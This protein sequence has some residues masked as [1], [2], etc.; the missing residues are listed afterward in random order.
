[1]HGQTNRAWPQR[2]VRVL[3]ITAV[4]AGWTFSANPAGKAPTPVDDFPLGMSPN[5]VK[6]RPVSGSSL[7]QPLSNPDAAQVSNPGPAPLPPD[8]TR[9]MKKDVLKLNFETMKSNAD[10]IVELSKSLQAEVDKSNENL[11]SLKIVDR[12]EKIEKLA[13]KIKELA[14]GY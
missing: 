6:P 14:R 11:L 10:E 7:H 5:Q 1:M 3:L 12:A 9:K 8:L 4:F 13:K 2:A